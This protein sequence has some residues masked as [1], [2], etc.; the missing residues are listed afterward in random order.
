VTRK[1]DHLKKHAQEEK[2]SGSHRQGRMNISKVPWTRLI[3]SKKQEG[4]LTLRL[5]LAWLFR[6]NSEAKAAALRWNRCRVYVSNGYYHL[7]VP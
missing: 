2:T 5:R 3:N 6:K 7:S 1:N 4:L